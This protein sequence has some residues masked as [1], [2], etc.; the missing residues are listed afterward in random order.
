MPCPHILFFVCSQTL[1]NRLC[2][3]STT[4]NLALLVQISYLSPRESRHIP[5]TPSR[6]SP[7]FITHR[8]PTSGGKFLVHGACL[9]LSA[10]LLVCDGS[11]G[12]YMPVVAEAVPGL[13]HVSL[14]LFVVG[15]GAFI[16]KINTIV[17]IGTIA[18]I[19][20]SGLLYIVALFSPVIKIHSPYQNS[21]SGLIWYL[22]RK[23]TG[24]GTRTG[25]PLEH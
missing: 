5:S 7:C 2:I 6:T 11:E 22:I 23:C 12:W 15:L 17:R 3:T 24:G 9:G 1:H 4:K 21:F 20:I 18:L 13:V 14:F 10:A 25:L 16:L 19:S 8:H